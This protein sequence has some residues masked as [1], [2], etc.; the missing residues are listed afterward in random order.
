VSD[1]LPFTIALALGAGGLALGLTWLQIRLNRV[2]RLTAAPREDRWHRNPTPSSG[3][4]A[5]FC[6][7]GLSYA[8]WFRGQHAPVALGAAA[9][10]LLGLVDD[11]LGLP[12]WAKLLGQSTASAL[13]VASGVVFHATS[14]TAF[15]LMFSFLW[16]VGITNAFNLIDNM[17]GLCAGVTVIIAAFRFSLLALAGSW[18]DANLC[19]LVAAAYGGFLILN[20]NPARIFMGDC[21]SMLAGFSLAALTIASPLA[22]TKA[23]VAG[24]FYPALTFAYPIFDTMLVSVL[25]KAAGRPISVGGRDHSSHRLVSTGLSESRA[26]AILWALAATGSAVGLMVRSMPM[27]LLAAGG[28]LALALTVFGLFLSTLPAYPLTPAWSAGNSRIRRYIPSLRAG[29]VLV[30]DVAA[31]GMALLLAFLVRFGTDIPTDQLRNL[32]FSLP[33]VMVMH[34]AFSGYRR[35]Y[36][37]SWRDFSLADVWPL[38]QSA[39]LAAA[40]SFLVIWMLNLRSFSRGVMVLYGLFCVAGSLSLRSSVP[41]MRM[42]LTKI[43]QPSR[44]GVLAGE[45]VIAAG[46][47]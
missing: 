45:A 26:V 46:A 20:R 1:H 29:V 22:H 13:V 33:I 31:A 21:G 19:A 47:D 40:C 35:T 30:M 24:V 15:N 11:L 34:A 43:P 25:R 16:L 28:M 18:T 39:A 10:W 17:D 12:P 42:L 9:L 5:I 6:A 27:A 14:S 44:D 32:A 8:L 36:A 2:L 41:I 23:F 37:L 38:A 7:M 3:G 4:I